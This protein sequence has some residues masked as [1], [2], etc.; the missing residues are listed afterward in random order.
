MFIREDSIIIESDNLKEISTKLAMY[1]QNKNAVIVGNAASGKTAI[2]EITIQKL[3]G[4][5]KL[6][7]CDDYLRQEGLSA[8][9]L[10]IE[11]HNMVPQSTRKKLIIEGCLGYRLLRKCAK[12]EIDFFPDIIV[13]IKVNNFQQYKFMELDERKIDYA[14]YKMNYL[15]MNKSLN[16][17]FNDFLN[18]NDRYFEHIIVENTFHR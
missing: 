6:I 2:A 9:M 16:T 1:F 14:E 11:R 10:S 8:L 12:R 17:I 18:I 3:D 7:Y 13:E 4:T 15:R 5:H